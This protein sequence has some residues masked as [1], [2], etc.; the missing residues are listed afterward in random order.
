MVRLGRHRCC[1]SQILG[2]QV[3]KSLLADGVA[4]P[5][6]QFDVNFPA[7]PLYFDCTSAML[8]DKQAELKIGLVQAAQ[9]C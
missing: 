9:E 2:R 1:G 5:L 4:S 3:A 8:H 7:I 6:D